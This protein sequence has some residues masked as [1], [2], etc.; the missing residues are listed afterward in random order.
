MYDGF[1][2]QLYW[3]KR[4]DLQIA[5]TQGT[6]ADPVRLTSPILSV[7]LI[8]HRSTILNLHMQFPLSYTVLTFRQSLK[9]INT[10]GR[11]SL[12]SGTLL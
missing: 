12:K 4:G 1:Y 5:L 8:V 7:H 2:L 6:V 9:H 11:T 10:K 3:Q